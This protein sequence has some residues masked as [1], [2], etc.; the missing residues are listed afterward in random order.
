[1]WET[2]ED[3]DED[4]VEDVG[5]EEVSLLLDDENEAQGRVEQ[6]DVCSACERPSV[7][8]ALAL[9]TLNSFVA[10]LDAIRS[11]ACVS[12]TAGSDAVGIVEASD[13]QYGGK[14]SA[15]SD[16]TN[17][18][19]TL[20]S[21]SSR[22]GEEEWASSVLPSLLLAL[23]ATVQL[24][25]AAGST[26]PTARC[27]STTDA[28]TG[29]AATATASGCCERRG[30]GSSRALAAQMASSMAAVRKS[31]ETKFAP[32]ASS[33]ASS[34]AP[35]NA[36]DDESGAGRTGFAEGLNESAEAGANEEEWVVI[37]REEEEGARANDEE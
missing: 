18:S 10:A 5:G 3:E 29:G 34:N 31:S 14:S 23:L 35:F 4:E 2:T 19:S 32:A 8:A 16:R 36:E 13:T 28:D 30:R 1:M 37:E 7:A 15:K 33:A 21:P 24:A 12:C 26:M 6:H 22:A 20:I 25:R 9:P 17:S 27:A 11:H